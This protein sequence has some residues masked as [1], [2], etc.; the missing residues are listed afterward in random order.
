MLTP[1]LP[2]P[3]RRRCARRLALAFPL[4]SLPLATLH[5]T[6]WP[7]WLGPQRDAVWRETGIVE[8]FPADG[9]K[10][11][12]RVP[13][14]GGYAGPAVAKGRVY[15]MD[16]LLAKDTTAPDNPFARG[17]IPGI[18]RVLCLNET[19]G[20]IL[21][22]HQYD[23]VYTVSYASGPRATP[24]V[25]DGKV[26]TLGAEGNLVCLDA[27]KGVVLWSRD[28]KRDFNLKT[29]L[30]G[31]AGHPLI[32]GNKLICLVGGEGSVAVAFDKDTG[33]NI[34]RALSAKEPGYAPPMIYEFAGKRQLIIWHPEAVNALDP[35]TG[36]IFWSYPLRPSVRSGMTIPTPRQSGDLL[37]LTSFYNG[38]LMMRVDSDK[39]VL[40]WQSKKVSEMDTDGLH[41]VMATPL[42]EEGYVY[43]PC[44][45]G[46]FRCLKADT[47]ERLWETFE[48]TTFKSTRW[49]NAFIVKNLASQDCFLLSETGDLII[50]KLTPQKYQ[51]ISRAH[52]LDPTNRD[53]GRRVVWS[54]PAF[55]NQSVYA[56]NDKEIVCVSLAVASAR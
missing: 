48:P 20:K 55:A 14:G 19:D 51:E 45:Y 2:H 44:S 28:V 18:E 36:K 47:G 4:V 40:V 25:S 16:R 17:E 43:S 9:L 5:A 50:A 27:E 13:I 11:R 54:H 38:S 52:L 3:F 53:P 23:C 10:Y 39:P 35:D 26:Y 37:F 1:K 6:D 49:G 33:K 32:D 22:Q 29:P 31:F 34:W 8:K 41:S 56:R 46:Q 42:L 15:V 7:Q 12:W 21:W 30:W 24:S